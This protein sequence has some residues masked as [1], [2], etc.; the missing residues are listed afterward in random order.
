[1][2][3]LAQ[4]LGDKYVLK[5]QKDNP[6]NLC[7]HMVRYIEAEIIDKKKLLDGEFV[8]AVLL[9]ATRQHTKL[10][11][12]IHVNRNRSSECTLYEGRVTI[13][14]DLHGQYRD[15][16]H[17]ISPNGPIGFPSPTN[18]VIFNGDMVD[19]GD[20]SVE[21]VVVLALISVLSPGS[22]HMLQGNHESSRTLN[23]TCGLSAELQLKFPNN[24]E[25]HEAFYK[26]LKSLPVAAV[27][28]DAVFVVHGGLG[29]RTTTIAR[30]NTTKHDRTEKLAFGSAF[31]E[32][33]WN[34]TDFRKGIIFNFL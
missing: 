21:I 26:L 13:V 29:R 22:V 28:D 15:L 19:R 25:L 32:L 17:L 33:L 4:L 7:E 20:M 8:L 31:L 34:G 5:V 11:N 9:E 14:G 18:Q 27:V 6:Q 23:D 12:V 16:Q 3:K 30:I 10:D 2:T 1:M 24:T